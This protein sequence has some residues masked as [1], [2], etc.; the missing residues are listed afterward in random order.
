MALKCVV[1]SEDLFQWAEWSGGIAAG[2]HEN[3]LALRDRNSSGNGGT[4]I[5][6]VPKP[7]IRLRLV[8]LKPLHISVT[9]QPAPPAAKS[10]NVRTLFDQAVPKG[11]PFKI[12]QG[13]VRDQVH[14]RKRDL[15][16][17]IMPGAFK[18]PRSACP[19]LALLG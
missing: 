5:A 12:G 3:V 8:A 17:V 19:Y 1:D 14:F 9:G 7:P 4:P 6:S 11:N 15:R 16:P 18:S 10:I 13:G 2:G